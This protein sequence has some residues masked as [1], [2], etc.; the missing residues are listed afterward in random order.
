MFAA[1]RLIHCKGRA[2]LNRKRLITSEKINLCGD[3]F[4]FVITARVYKNKIPCKEIKKYAG[5]Y[6]SSLIFPESKSEAVSEL[7]EIR[8]FNSSVLFLSKSPEPAD[9]RSVCV[10][11]RNSL[12]CEHLEKLIPLASS[13]HVICPEKEKYYSAAEYILREYGAAV[14]VS[15]EWGGVADFCNNVIASDSNIL[16]LGYRGRVFT[17]KRR[18]LPFARLIS[19]EGII[20]PSEYEKVLPEKIDRK[21]F[22][23]ALYLKCGIKELGEC[24]YERLCY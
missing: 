15:A 17:L 11:D 1:V 22:A 6:A 3:A 18:T 24:A 21:V 7:D 12:F 20:L 9:N 16:P 4:F 8:L 13:L 19:G 2:P 14:S 23:E 10:Y 5:R